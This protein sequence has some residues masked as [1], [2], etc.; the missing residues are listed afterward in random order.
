VLSLKAVSHWDIAKHVPLD[1]A[2]SYTELSSKS[3][4]ESAALRRLMRHAITNGIFCEPTKENIAHNSMSR[5]LIEDKRTAAWVD[6]MTERLMLGAAHQ[7]EALDK[8]P[9]SGA[10]RETGVSIGFHNPGQTSLYEEV[11]KKPE[12]IVNFGLAM[13]LFSSGEGYEFHS[14][15]EGYDWGRLGEGTVVDVSCPTKSYADSSQ[16]NIL[17]NLVPNGNWLTSLR[18]VVQTDLLAQPSPMPILLLRS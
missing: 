14:L 9:G 6:L 17:V 2:I 8:W 3:G 4:L 5:I 15:V 16:P 12:T 11:K 7:C 10:H 18:L 1:E 13:E